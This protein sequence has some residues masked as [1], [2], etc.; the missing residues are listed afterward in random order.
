MQKATSKVTGAVQKAAGL[1][2]NG[3]TQKSQVMTAKPM[4]GSASGSRYMPT[5]EEK[6][7]SAAA[8]VSAN[9][10][11]QLTAANYRRKNRG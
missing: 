10:T 11:D 8:A 1:N 9:M 3:G 4:G 6:A 2:K 7:K 5:N